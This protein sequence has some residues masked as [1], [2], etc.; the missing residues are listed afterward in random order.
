MSTH[1]ESYH[2]KHQKRLQTS[3]LDNNGLGV[4]IVQGNDFNIH[5]K[6]EGG[7]GCCCCCCCCCCCGGT[8]V[9]ELETY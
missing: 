5:A 2:Q 3:I 7:G 9:A 8:G 4:G 1:T 6:K